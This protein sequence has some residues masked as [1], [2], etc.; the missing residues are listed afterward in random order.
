MC[1]IGVKFRAVDVDD[2]C[3]AEL[4]VDACEQGRLQR[5]SK[6]LAQAEKFI[7]AHLIRLAASA[8]FHLFCP[9]VVGALAV[10][11]RPDSLFP[12]IFVLALGTF[13]DAAARETHKLRFQ[14]Y[15][16]L[17]QILPQFSVLPL[18]IILAP[19]VTVV[20]LHTVEVN[21][22]VSGKLDNQF[23]ICIPFSLYGLFDMDP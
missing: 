3:G 20:Q 4:A 23:A 12:V 9:E 7:K 15:Q 6:V 21:K 13:H 5:S 10:V 18:R 16:R 17:Y 22:A 14:I 2:L 19:E 8:I 11:K 1:D